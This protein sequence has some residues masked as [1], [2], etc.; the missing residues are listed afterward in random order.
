MKAVQEK[1]A[2]GR[3]AKAFLLDRAGILLYNHCVVSV[4][5]RQAAGTGPYTAES[6]LFSMKKLTLHIRNTPWSILMSRYCFGCAVLVIALFIMH[7]VRG[8]GHGLSGN[9]FE[10]IGASRDTS[11][12]L[13][14]TCFWAGTL[15][16]SL[17]V[18][19]RREIRRPALL[20][21]GSLLAIAI[22]FRIAGEPAMLLTLGQA[23]CLAAFMTVMI[24]AALFARIHGDKVRAEWALTH[25]DPAPPSQDPPPYK[26]QT[27]KLSYSD[28]V[29]LKAVVI[30]CLYQAI[31]AASHVRRGESAALPLLLF[32]MLLYIGILYVQALRDA[33]LPW[34]L[35]T[36]RI[37]CLLA[38][39]N[40]VLLLTHLLVGRYEP[41]AAR[42]CDLTVLMES[43]WWPDQ[44]LPGCAFLMCVLSVLMTLIRKET[45]KTV[46]CGLLLWLPFICF[47]WSAPDILNCF[48]YRSPVSGDLIALSWA[49]FAGVYA[50]LFERLFGREVIA[51]WLVRRETARIKREGKNAAP[52]GNPAVPVRQ[53]APSARKPVTPVSPPAMPV[54]PPAAQKTP[55]KSTSQIEKELALKKAQF[56]KSHSAD[57]PAPQAQS[58]ARLL[59]LA[60][61][62]LFP[63]MG[64]LATLDGQRQLA[65][66]LTAGVSCLQPLTDTDAF[67]ALMRPD[68]SDD[69]NEFLEPLNAFVKKAKEQLTEKVFDD[70]DHWRS[71][72]AERLTEGWF[73]L[74]MYS[75]MSSEHEVFEL[76]RDVLAEYIETRPDAVSYLE[77]AIKY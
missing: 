68:L 5:C 20:T 10:R 64:T 37:V 6:V 38:V 22:A 45:R 42:G 28:I 47:V 4:L 19:T 52:A 15:A 53:P 18:L 31:L 66:W 11:D 35:L 9:V 49:L 56:E 30:L 13:L 69:P 23:L 8:G 43:Q 3:W 12:I 33:P 57:T 34:P 67:A 2:D 50:M 54:S 32:G 73:A 39:L 26:K 27:R 21:A 44:L 61:P 76:A 41:R 75:R 40:L 48:R 77:D 74:S 71:L 55:E 62:R 51:E 63:G 65:W 25:K 24:C 70:R 7:L 36:C 14:R 46:F 17:L 72:D 60:R 59:E 29:P 16:G 1:C 58:A